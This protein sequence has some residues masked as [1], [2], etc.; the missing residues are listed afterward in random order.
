MGVYEGQEDNIF[1]TKKNGSLEEK[2]R[3]K[4]TTGDV[5]LLEPDTIHAV[6]NPLST[7]SKALH[8]YGAN[9]FS[10]TRSMWNPWTME[11]SPFELYQF[12]M[13]SNTMTERGNP[14]DREPRP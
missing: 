1:Y 5:V 2:D 10:T 3:K 11:E 9:L 7:P 6:S 14:S 4:L 8:V 13:W 12:L